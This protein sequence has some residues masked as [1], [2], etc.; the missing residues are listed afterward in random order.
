[1]A[2]H[3]DVLTRAGHT[4]ECGGQCGS[5]RHGPNLPLR[6][7]GRRHGLTV[8]AR[9][10]PETP[11]EQAAWLPASDLVAWCARCLQHARLHARQA[12]VKARAD[13]R[14][15]ELFGVSPSTG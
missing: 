4:C 13:T 1:M 9:R 5:N 3:N 14:D 15:A 2:A 12:R 8:V 7:C 11:P 6:R 10:D